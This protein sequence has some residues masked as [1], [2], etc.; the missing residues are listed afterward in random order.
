M[1][2]P[3]SHTL[4][5]FIF[6]KALIAS[7]SFLAASYQ[8]PP[9]EW[10]VRKSKEFILFPSPSASRTLLG[11]QYVLSTC[12]LCVSMTAEPYQPPTPRIAASSARDDQPRMLVMA[13][14]ALL[15]SHP[16]PVCWLL[17]LSFCS[18]IPNCKPV[19][20]AQGA[21]QTWATENTQ[22][23]PGL[24]TPRPKDEGMASGCWSSLGLRL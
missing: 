20:G 2:K 12:L 4:S 14:P 15:F 13:L 22:R 21:P 3:C 5:R 11:K 1:A 8:P 24:H 18:S 23:P 6:I 16:F 7:C 10:Q 19:Y 9:L 17:S